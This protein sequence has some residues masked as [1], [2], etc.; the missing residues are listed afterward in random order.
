MKPEIKKRWLEA[1]ITY[2]K[3]GYYLKTGDRFSAV[4]VLCDLYLK[5][6]DLPWGKEYT[7]P[8]GEIANSFKE[9]LSLVTWAGLPPFGVIPTI[10]I[11]SDNSDTFE[12]VIKYI[13]ENL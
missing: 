4:G 12:P 13:E 1:L 9:G 6:M 5:E 7:T 3:S 8:T 11:I 2:K 10:E